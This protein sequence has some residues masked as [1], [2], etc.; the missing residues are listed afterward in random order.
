MIVCSQALKT[1]IEAPA[2]AAAASW[3]LATM[4][5]TVDGATVR[6]LSDKAKVSAYVNIRWRLG[7][8]CFKIVSGT[9]APIPDNAEG[10]DPNQCPY[11]LA[12]VI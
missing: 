8:E 4:A 6:A 9:F 2:D 5:L 12:L 1:G 7:S 3:A 10:C 11:R